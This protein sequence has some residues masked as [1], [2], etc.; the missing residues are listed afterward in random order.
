MS[1]K[2]ALTL[3]IVVFCS[4][5]RVDIAL[6]AKPLGFGISSVQR[7]NLERGEIN[8]EKV[9]YTLNLPLEWSGG[10]LIAERESVKSGGAIIEKVIFSYAP[11]NNKIKPV[12]LMNFF[13]YDRRYYKEKEREEKPLIE[14]D[15]YVYAKTSSGVNPFTNETDKALF[16]R[17]MRDAAN[18][19]FVTRFI[20]LPSDQ[21]II[22]NNT[23]TIC[24][25]KII[26]KSEV[27]EKNVVYIPLRETLEAVG[28]KIGWL[29]KERAT[30]ISK[31]DFYHL[32]LLNAR[33]PS[34]GYKTVIINDRMYVT[35]MFFMQV[36]NADI[37]IDDNYNVFISV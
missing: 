21:K 28:Y 14:T 1:I 23:V 27:I 4:A 24:G 31:G 5:L 17:F 19:S 32:A 2:R 3:I 37:E 30:T 36:L 34:K 11:Q 16:D 8:G 22:Y 15:E 12:F 10:Y 7:L 33:Q 29:E 20:N 35:S 25:E 9:D 26:G 13:V 18:D 6:A